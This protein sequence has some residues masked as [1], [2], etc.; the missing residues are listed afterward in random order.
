MPLRSMYCDQR[1]YIDSIN[2]HDTSQVYSKLTNLGAMSPDMFCFSLHK[3]ARPRVLTW[4]LFFREETKAP[5]PEATGTTGEG[6]GVSWFWWG[7]AMRYKVRVQ[8]EVWSPTRMYL[9]NLL[10]DVG[11]LGL[12]KGE[13]TPSKVN[14]DLQRL[15]IKR[16]LWITWGIFLLHLKPR[17]LCICPGM[18]KAC[19]TQGTRT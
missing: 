9:L 15:G 6:P 5:A 12:A 2:L 14:R 13:V 19:C 8:G 10:M 16:S 7:W 1:S 3:I 17:S 11:P 18:F 4:N